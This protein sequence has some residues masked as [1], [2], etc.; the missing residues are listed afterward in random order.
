MRFASILLLATILL[1]AAVGFAEE[2]DPYLWLEE[3]DGEKALEWVEERT[4]ADG[5]AAFADLDA[6][7]SG[8]A[9]ILLR[10]H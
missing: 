8:A 5:A 10:P 7:R 3:V 2:T 9:K 6:G 1:S 4:L